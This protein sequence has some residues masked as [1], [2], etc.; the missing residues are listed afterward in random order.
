MK[1]VAQPVHRIL[2]GLRKK[3]EKKLEELLQADIF[4]EVPEGPTGWISLLVVVP[5]NDGDVRVCV[6]ILRA[7]EAIIRERHPI[8]TVAEL[9]HASN[10][11]TAFSKVAWK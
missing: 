8:P 3:V 6:D 1:P 7:N 9:L 11:C 10:G 5:K 2:F 4:E